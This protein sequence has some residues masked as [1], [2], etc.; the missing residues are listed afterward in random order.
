MFNILCKFKIFPCII[1]S[2]SLP[3][4]LSELCEKGNMKFCSV[5]YI[6]SLVDIFEQAVDMALALASKNR[7]NG[8]K[9]G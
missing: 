1:C 2:E 4:M 7:V 9:E 3:K 5:D 8:V 6:K